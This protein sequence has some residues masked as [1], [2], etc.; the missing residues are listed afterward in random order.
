MGK[1]C[2]ENATGVVCEDIFS[3]DSDLFAMQET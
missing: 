2:C 1:K 3:G